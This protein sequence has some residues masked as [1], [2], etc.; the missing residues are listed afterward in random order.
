MPSLYS[1]SYQIKLTLLLLLS[2]SFSLSLLSFL[3]LLQIFYDVR[4]L[5]RC[6]L[7]FLLSYGDADH[8]D[9]VGLWFCTTPPSPQGQPSRAR[10]LGPLQLT[11][12]SSLAFAV[13]GVFSVDIYCVSV[14]DPGFTEGEFLSLLSHLSRRSILLLEDIDSAGLRRESHRSN[15]GRNESGISLSG[16]LNAM[17]GVASSERRILIMTSNVPDNLDSALT[18]WPHRSLMNRVGNANADIAA[19]DQV[20]EEIDDATAAVEER[21]LDS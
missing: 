11:G 1:P 3:G 21:E 15:D 2:L 8:H 6:P 13:A 10:A 12:K 9:H 19:L 14:N 7:P 4:T 18:A 17:D 5:I 16:L 20:N